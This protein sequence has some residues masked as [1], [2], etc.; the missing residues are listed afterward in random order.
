M[1]ASKVPVRFRFGTK[2]TQQR[3]ILFHFHVPH[4]QEGRWFNHY[5]ARTLVTAP[6][7]SDTFLA[8]LKAV[9]DNSSE[10]IVRTST[11]RLTIAHR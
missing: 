8:V 5:L 7:W 9:V 2:A 6:H 11:S 4:D 1:L 10:I 3:R